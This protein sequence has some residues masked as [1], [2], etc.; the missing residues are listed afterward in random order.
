ME[1]SPPSTSGA[2][3]NGAGV[4]VGT[5]QSSANTSLDYAES[6]DEPAQSDELDLFPGGLELPHFSR[7]PRNSLGGERRNSHRYKLRS[8][9]NQEGS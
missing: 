4:G 3:C 5:R 8:L 9:K 7:S 6:I 1:P 2:S